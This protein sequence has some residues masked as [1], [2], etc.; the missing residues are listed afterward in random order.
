MLNVVQM[1]AEAFNESLALRNL[2]ADGFKNVEHSR[3]NLEQRVNAM[4]DVHMKNMTQLEITTANLQQQITKIQTDHG[5]QISKLNTQLT[6]HLTEK[7]R[8]TEALTDLNIKFEIQDK[9]IDDLGEA[10]DKLR[11]MKSQAPQTSELVDFK[12][13]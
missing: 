9:Q 3:A 6:S 7:T 8:L 4:E 12:L 11:A 2:V 13:E 10:V 1:I 5:I